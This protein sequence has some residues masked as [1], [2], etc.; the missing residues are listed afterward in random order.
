MLDVSKRTLG[1][2]VLCCVC[3][4][5]CLMP[6]THAPAGE[7][8]LKN[9]SFEQIGK[10]GVPAGWQRQYNKV[11]GGPFLVVADA[12][13]GDRAVCLMT[14]EW[15]YQRPQFIT[16][17]VKLPP[18]AKSLQLSAYCK[19]QGMVSL[20]FRFLKGDQ[21]HETKELNLVFGRFTNPVELL[22]EFSLC[23]TY[24]RYEASA[25]IPEGADGVMVKLGNSIGRLHRLNIWGKVWVD[26]ASLTASATE[27]PEPEP[28][29]ELTEKLELPKGYRDVAPFSRIVLQPPCFDMKPLV[30]GDI[31]T[32]PAHMGG[33]GRAGNVSFL[34]A[35]PVPVHS[36]CLHLRGNVRSLV[37]RGDTEGD[38]I[39]ETVLARVAGLSEKGWLTLALEQRPM[40]AIR[41]QPLSGSISGF[42]HASPFMSEAKVLVANSDYGKACPR[43][44]GVLPRPAA[45]KRGVTALSLRPTEMELPKL[46]KSRFRRM[47]CADLWMWGVQASKKDSK[48]VDCRQ[49]GGFRRTVEMA[50]RMG[51]EAI[52]IDLTNSSGWNLM[53]WPSKVCNG[54]KE[55][56]LRPLIE[57]LHEEGFEV[58]VEIIHNV[59]PFETIK[60]HYPEEE[61]SRYPGMKQYPSIIHGSHVRDNWLTIMDEIMA[62]GADGVG[63]SSDEQYY[64]GHF[65]ETFPKD[66]PGRAL[67]KKRFGYELPEHEEDTLKFRQWIQMRHEGICDLFGYWT[68]ELKKKY[69]S[70]YTGTLLMSYAH[71]YSYLTETGIPVDLLGARAGITEIGSDYMGPYGIRM[72]AAANG[73]RRATMVHDGDMW[74]H[75]PHRDLHYYKT[76]LWNLMYGA[77]SVN[78]WRFN[79]VFTYGHA[80]VLTRAYSMVR[81]LDALGLWEAQPSRQITMLSSRAGIDWWQIKAWWG[82]HEDPRWDRGRE[83]QRGWFAD[84]SVFYML[85]RNG[86]PFDWRFMDYADRLRG[87][88]QCK[89]IL[90]PF[91]YSVS[92]EA[93][94]RIKAAAESGAKV[95]L[96]DGLQG[97]TDEWGEPHPEPVL[98]DLV[99]S[100]KAVLFEEDILTW[101]SAESF[102]GK[103]IAAIDE[104]VGEE[105]AFKLHRYG[106]KIDATM[107]EKETGERF[108][109]LINHEK[110]P[111]TV[112]LE[113]SLP[114]GKYEAF[115]RDDNQ[116]YRVSKKDNPI[117]S[118]DDLRNFRLALAPEQPYVVYVRKAQ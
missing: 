4:V 101:G 88:E 29:H 26:S 34:F 45:P 7:N 41:I 2:A 111:A 80:S 68:T 87:L 44:W 85:Q 47:I 58:F 38:G 113:L 49:S 72:A 61:T 16:Q 10:D 30:D 71:A 118:Q 13:D 39:Y 9:P 64:K 90:I 24:D 112:D 100:G 17:T 103:V 57:A 53:P 32:S 33:I 109:F 106:L 77:G 25:T 65:M 31:E 23:Q 59:T 12:H 93:A 19:G 70:I 60:W 48:L 75:P 62:C 55:N 3:L 83:G 18:G 91:A 37:V 51:V 74:P 52:L 114:A 73:W 79:Y 97:P 28:T 104:A 98:K 105:P 66:D 110:K 5:T 63:I 117:L 116:W 89:V 99:E 82:P 54:T 95:F 81:D 22:N 42:R 69:P 1:G 102:V 20:A 107:L 96:F 84:Q 6:A 14:E 11:L 67:Y 78:Y 92:K 76:A 50:K 36:V 40:K 56:H 8:L 108:V 35:N 21:P 115:A 94:A 27:P 43:G 86:Y 15:N 46:E